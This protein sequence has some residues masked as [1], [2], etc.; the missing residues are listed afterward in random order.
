MGNSHPGI[1]FYEED[2]GKGPFKLR[3][4]GTSDFVTEIYI[5]YY[6]RF[7]GPSREKVT[8]SFGWDNPKALLYS[9]LSKAIEAAAHAHRIEGLHI[10][11]EKEES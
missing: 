1:F 7:G 9:D 11:I 2:R 10:S 8:T 3:I 4:S 6:G 5:N